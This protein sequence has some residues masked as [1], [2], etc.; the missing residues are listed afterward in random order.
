M[1]SNILKDPVMFLGGLLISIILLAVP[2]FVVDYSFGKT[3]ERQAFVV[4]KAYTPSSVGT[5]VGPTISGNGG[6]AVVVT[7]TSSKAILFVKRFGK[8]EEIAVSKAV[9][10]STKIGD[11][12]SYKVRIGWLSG[13]EY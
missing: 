7:T 1:L 10:L 13:I 5:G 2:A 3:I 8:V 4:E 6:I 12:V 11:T 9:W